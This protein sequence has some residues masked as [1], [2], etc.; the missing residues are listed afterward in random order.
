MRARQGEREREKETE[1]GRE[2]KTILVAMTS[3]TNNR[4]K[5]KSLAFILLS[6]S[7]RYPLYDGRETNCELSE[8]V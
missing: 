3:V 2:I 4:Q 5:K 8:Y 6:P 1:T 7:T